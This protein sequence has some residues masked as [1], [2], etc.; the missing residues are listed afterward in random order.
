MVLQLLMEAKP[1]ETYLQISVSKNSVVIHIYYPKLIKAAILWH[2]MGRRGKMSSSWNI[3][4]RN[5]FGRNLTNGQ[6][7]A[8][9]A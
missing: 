1:C 4:K 9:I 8:A 7:M 2:N 3:T 5:V 6:G